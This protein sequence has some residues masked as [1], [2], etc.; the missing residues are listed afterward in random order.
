LSV[1]QPLTDTI[2]TMSGKQNTTAVAVQKE[3]LVA[4]LRPTLVA[5]PSLPSATLL[6]QLQPLRLPETTNWTHGFARIDC[7]GR[8]RDAFLFG[9]LGWQPGERL[10]VAFD[11]QKLVVRRDRFGEGTLDARGRLSL[12]ESARR[13]L[14]L[15]DGDGV[16][17]SADLKENYLVVSPARRCDEVLKV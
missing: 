4:A 9:H 16:L 10:V 13:V 17:L 2:T 8:V 1:L 14:H 6:S 3:R 5:L 12:G 7:S 11:G 15:E